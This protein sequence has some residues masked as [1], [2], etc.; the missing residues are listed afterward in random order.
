ML[1]GY[2]WEAARRRAISETPPPADAFIARLRSWMAVVAAVGVI[3]ALYGTYQVIARSPHIYWLRKTFYLD[4]ATGT[5]VNRAHLAGY[6]ELAIPIG[7]SLALSY[8]PWERRHRRGQRH[9]H[10]VLPGHAGA[11]GLMLLAGVALMLLAM[12]LTQSRGGVLAA[13]G[14]LALGAAA[15]G[16]WRRALTWRRLALGAG[17]F[18]ALALVWLQSPQLIRRFSGEL[19]VTPYSRP[20]LWRETLVMVRDFPLFGIGLGNFEWLFPRYQP[21]GTHTYFDRAHNDYL[22]LVVESGLLG[23]GCFAWLFVRFFMLCWRG[24]RTA[25]RDRVLLA[26]GLTAGVAALLLHSLTDFNLHL[27]SNALLFVIA[28]AATVRLLDAGSGS[29]LQGRVPLRSRAVP[30]AGLVVSGLVALVVMR[31][32]WVESLVRSIFP[33]SSLINPLARPPDP[34]PTRLQRVATARQ[35]AP[36]QVEVVEAIGAFGRQVG[37]KNMRQRA[38]AESEARAR[39]TAVVWSAAARAYVHMV[40]LRPSAAWPHVW[41]AQSLARLAEVRHGFYLPPEVVRAAADLFDRGVAL[42]PRDRGLT[43]VAAEWGLT[44]WGLLPAQDQARAADWARQALA[45]DPL[46]GRE[47][48]R[49]AILWDP[50]LPQR[51]LP[52]EREVRLYLALAYQD[53]QRPDDA[54]RVAAGLEEDLSARLRSAAAPAADALLLGRVREYRG[55]WRGAAEAYGRAAVLAADDDRRTEALKRSGYS[56][57]NAGDN[58]KAQQALTAARRYG[59]RDPDVLAGLSAVYEQRGDYAAAA[60]LVRD[61]AALAPGAPEYRYRLARLYERGRKYGK[62]NEQYKRLLDDAGADFLKGRRVEL[63]LALAR[64]Y[65]QLEV[66][67]EARRFYELVLQHAPDNHE[68]REFLALFGS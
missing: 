41:L 59:G 39:Q 5:F 52:A 64:N 42:Q 31:N 54:A 55:N 57:L 27:P 61:A 49:L 40:E 68:A 50:A 45:I 3:E 4:S 14:G 51:M 30:V 6:F 16:V 1:I 46:R 58:V 43:R 17:V 53:A 18:A 67:P 47:L 10:R 33:N 8:I 44:H 62:A 66:G 20:S 36:G 26:L 9:H 32:W 7:I 38:Y 19:Q 21:V 48:L 12:G 35:V 13:L 2:P 11:V 29:G 60:R 56:W 37:E 25:E 28:V 15:F 34:W 63:L 23:A 65:R 22:Q 24:L